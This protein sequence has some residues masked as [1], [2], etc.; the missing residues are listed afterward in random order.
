MTAYA[1]TI[2]YVLAL[3][4][5]VIGVAVFREE[6]VK[7]VKVDP[8]WLDD[9]YRELDVLGRYAGPCWFCGGP[10]KR[11]RLAD[12]I[13]GGVRAGDSPEETARSYVVSVETVNALVAGWTR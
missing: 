6:A 9:G 1:E 7:I 12:S 10:D 13:V 8:A 5:I 11:H 2:L 3:L 4:A